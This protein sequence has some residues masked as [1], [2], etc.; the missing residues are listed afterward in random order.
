MRAIAI[1]ALLVC[2]AFGLVA[3]VVHLFDRGSSNRETDKSVNVVLNDL[4]K[5]QGKRLTID[6]NV[7]T[8]VAPWAV[9][10]GSSD[11]TQVGVLVVSTKR[12]PPGVRQAT[13]VAATGLAKPFS[14]AGFRRAHPELTDR[15]L[16]SSPLV[17]LNGQPA[18][19]DAS[20][21]VTAPPTDSGG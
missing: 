4:G 13:H 17:D 2:V 20:V 15:A 7:K 8:R 12:L 16:G 6:G 11:A 5:V 14:L 3:G 10:L 21:S 1:T 18:L 9:L 19:V